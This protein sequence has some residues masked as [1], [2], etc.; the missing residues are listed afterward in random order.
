MTKVPISYKEIFTVEFSQKQEQILQGA[1]RIFLGAGYAGTSMDRVSAE[2]S[3]SKQTIYSHFG[4]KQG[5]FKALMEWVTLAN[6]RSVFDGEELV[7]EPAVLLRRVG[8]IFFTRVADNPDYLGL[9]R[10]I[11]GESERFP[12]L[13][14]LYTQTVVN[15]GRE[16]LSEYFSLHEELGI[17]DP[18]AIAHIFFGSLVSHIIVQE[19]LYGKEIM[20]L[21]RDRLLDS[22]IGLVLTQPII[23]NKRHRDKDS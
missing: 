22:L 21:S 20:P 17:N 18:E 4:D 12:E 8:E 14:K 9:I 1:M 15:Q 6:F 23:E 5:L 11:I 10:L 7:G 3:V 16:I 19:M 2:A 13:A